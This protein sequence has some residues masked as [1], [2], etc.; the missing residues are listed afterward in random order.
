MRKDLETEQLGFGRNNK[1]WW[2]DPEEY[3]DSLKQE[4]NN[5]EKRME[6]IHEVE[7]RLREH[8]EKIMGE[9]GLKGFQLDDFTLKKPEQVYDNPFMRFIGFNYPV[10][11][12]QHVV[13]AKSG[14]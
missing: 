7:A 14:V 3:K 1:E 8:R 11:F 13:L 10:R 12:F 2:N 6:E 9:H 4:K 5:L